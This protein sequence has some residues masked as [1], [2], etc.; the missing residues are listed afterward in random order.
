MFTFELNHRHLQQNLKK[1]EKAIGDLTPSCTAIDATGAPQPEAAQ[2]L[3]ELA[4]AHL[5]QAVGI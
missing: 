2:A 1:V 4:L 5:Q 3:L